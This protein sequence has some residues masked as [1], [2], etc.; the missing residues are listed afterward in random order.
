M[1]RADVN[2]QVMRMAKRAENAPADVLHDAF[3]P[4]PSLLAQL[5]SSEHQVLYGR[6]GTGKTHV[7]RYVREQRASEGALTVYLDLRQ[8]GAAEDVFSARQE[9]FA[10]HATRLLVDVLEHVHTQVY[11]QLLTD[12]W[13]H[14]LS[15]LAT[16][17]DALAA[18]AT[19]VRVVGESEVVSEHEDTT[20][21]TRSQS[22]NLQLPDPRA[23]W[24][25]A[26]GRQDTQRH[27]QR[28]L[29]RGHEKH[30]V[31]LGPL[32]TAIR[33]LADAIR[34]Q[35]LWLLIDEWSAVPLEVQPLVAD[36]LRR[37]F[38][39]VRGIT[40]KISALHGRSR[41]ADLDQG[42][43]IGLE[44][45]ADTSATLDLDDYLT[46]HHDAAATLTFYAT[47]LHRH[48]S[49]TVSRVGR[50]AALPAGVLATPNGL[51]KYLFAEM[52]AFHRLVI[53]AEAIPRDALQI[54]GL[55]ARPPRTT[56]P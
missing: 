24:Q 3:V 44:L 14:R 36:L 29:D 30:H 51:I 31:L 35:E 1:N 12:A 13:S 22:L 49:A 7:L 50:S 19:Q 48:L 37:T 40:V 10:D 41:F 34:P 4:V 43:N 15:E 8:I 42:T 47:L 45:G 16:A 39:P 18:A 27:S 9:T 5:T 25:A 56:A 23:A 11:D 2:T 54:V 38:F 33:A 17:L 46:F 26:S 6:R 52:E 20:Q 55:A 21:S 32:T 53:A 28:R